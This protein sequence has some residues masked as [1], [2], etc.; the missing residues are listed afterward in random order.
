[1]SGEEPVP[2]PLPK[3]LP[4][5]AYNVSLGRAVLKA[6]DRII[7][8]FTC[9]VRETLELYVDALAERELRWFLKEQDF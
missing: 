4:A 7:S 9:P 2:D 5:F 6:S 3:R 1:L 8:G